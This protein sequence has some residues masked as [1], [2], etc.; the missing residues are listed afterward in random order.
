MDISFKHL[1]EYLHCHFSFFFF[2]IIQILKAIWRLTVYFLT[3]FASFR[4]DC[5]HKRLIIFHTAEFLLDSLFFY[6]FFYVEERLREFLWDWLFINAF[7]E[8]K[9]KC[10]IH[11]LAEKVQELTFIPSIW[12]FYWGSRGLAVG[13]GCMIAELGLSYQVLVY[14]NEP[15]LIY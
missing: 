13:T 12:L 7:L 2:I 8:A 5:C 3:T 4:I 9:S 1:L 14:S 6:N 11:Y 15:W 10:F